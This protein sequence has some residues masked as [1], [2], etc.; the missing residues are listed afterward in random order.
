MHEYLMYK[1]LKHEGQLYAI[2]ITVKYV[3]VRFVTIGH[4]QKER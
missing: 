3:F 2:A 1:I 4:Q